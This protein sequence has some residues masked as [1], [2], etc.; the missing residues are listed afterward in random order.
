[1]AKSKKTRQSDSKTRPEEPAAQARSTVSGPATLPFSTESADDLDSKMAATA[2]L[3]SAIP[4]NPLKPSEF[5]PNAAATPLQGQWVKA[6][7]QAATGNTLSE[8]NG[9]DKVG[10]GAPPIGKNRTIAP[11]NPGLSVAAG[12]AGEAPTD[13]FIRA[14]AAH[15][16]YER[17]S[18]PPRL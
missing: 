17:E 3:A 5:D 7:D 15:R 6:S 2:V 12:D 4:F 13:A 11:L 18:D 1:M 10:S 14:V 16:H 9:S 8:A